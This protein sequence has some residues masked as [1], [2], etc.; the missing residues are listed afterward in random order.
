MVFDNP[1]K[2]KDDYSQKT[3]LADN[4]SAECH[5]HSENPP[6]LSLHF[7]GEP[8]IG[9]A[10]A[11]TT[12]PPSRK[13]RALL[14][15]LAVTGRAHRR[16]RLCALLW[17]R[18]DDPRGALRWSLSKLRRL[19]DGPG[20][21]RILAGRETVRFDPVGAHIDIVDLRLRV[22]HG[23][24]TGAIEDLAAAAAAFSGEF[25]AGL[26]LRDSHGFHAWCI[27]ERAELH[28]LH[29]R[30]LR[31]LA[32]KLKS[33]PDATLP[34]L[35]SLLQ[36]EPHDE[37]AWADLVQ[38]L[39]V[40]GRRQEA[41]DQAALGQQVLKEAG[42]EPTGALLK[43]MQNLP[44]SADWAFVP[45][46]ST[47]TGG[48]RGLPPAGQTPRLA[49]PADE[50]AV[51]LP[52]QAAPG[53]QAAL[54]AG[55]PTIV[56]VPFKAI[57][58]DSAPDIF[59]DG[60]SEDLTT[61]L[62]R[63]LGLFVIARGSAFHFKGRPSGALE[64]VR[65]LGVRYALHGSV[66]MTA[67]RIRVHAYL[68]DSHAGGEIWSERYDVAHRDVFAVQDEIA[69]HVVRALQVEL[70]E[71]EQARVWHRSTESIEAWSWLTQGLA[72]YKRQTREGVQKARALFEK[73]TQA[74]P[75]YA[76]AWAW[77]AYAYWHDAR[78]LWVEEPEKALARAAAIV[79]RALALDADVS[80]VHA[81]LGAI[82]VLRREYDEAIAAARKAVT[83][84]PNGAEA[85]ALL[86]FVLSWAGQ[87]EEAMQIAGRAIEF[88]PI[89]SA[90][91]LDTLAHSQWLLGLVDRAVVSYHRA[92]TRLPNYIMPRIGLA[93]CYAEMGRFVE[94]GEQ[95]RE[96][97][98]ID[99]DFSIDRHTA[100]SQYRLPEHAERRLRALRAA[101]LP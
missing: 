6:L 37:G 74:D 94:A 44:R 34:H 43:V 52:G 63:V 72:Q 10:G 85:A 71:G 45:S 46:A 56:V 62:S 93:A 29:L 47:G 49:S 26:D 77:L 57:G 90:W 98:R 64:A 20:T 9:R 91:Y 30:V 73:A 36:L 88:C 17:E 42:V 14:A 76:A 41:R 97:L 79:E 22:A 35:R 40:Q 51:E 60:V 18:P 27:A 11:P 2:S 33:Q 5:N 86:A 99:P 80:E 31:I 21:V 95:A 19:V 1:L 89:H 4:A 67:D 82:H 66:R 84:D 25:L 101:G 8:R 13:T 28:A 92:I 24:E 32:G 55:K 75:T 70:L 53:R 3:R 39:A 61:M 50:Q 100:M 38:L 68:L 59:A 7:L 87:P 78:F 54:G 48:P 96:V 81:V 12:L 83:L 69:T 15:Y 58:E 16:D 23:L 65:E